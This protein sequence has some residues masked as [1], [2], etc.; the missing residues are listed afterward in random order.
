LICFNP[1]SQLSIKLM[2]SSNFSTWQAQVTTLLFG[3]DLLSYIDGTTIIPPVYIAD[4]KGNQ[5]PNPNY[6]FWLRQDSLVRSAIMASVD[7]SIAPLIAKAATAKNAW[8]SLQM[9]YAN[10]S[11]VRIFGLHESLSNIKR[12][13]K[14]VRD[15]MKEIK[16]IADDLAAS[17]SPLTN[18][19]LVIKVL[20]GLGVEYKEISVAIRARDNPISFEELFEKLLAHEVFVQHSESKNEQ[21]I[22]TAQFSQQHTSF[23][24]SKGRNHT[25]SQRRGGHSNFMPNKRNFSRQLTN[26][27][28]FN[29]TSNQQRV[30]CKLCAKFG[31]IA[32]VCRSK[33]HDA[34]EAQ[35][36]FSNHANYAANH[37]SSWIVDSGTSHHITDNPNS[38]QS[39]THFLGND[40][41]IIGEGKRIP[42]THIGQTTFSYDNT[43]PFHLHNVFCSPRIKRNLILVAKFCHHNQASIEFFPYSFCVKDL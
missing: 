2:G 30:Q 1:A 13:S 27:K 35:A 3:Y 36:N 20:S 16:S 29:N 31:H 4:D 34:L 15:Y 17:G 11:Q 9:T 25:G 37:S 14:S 19:E 18:E 26:S 41:I 32:K 38:L 5:L 39:A 12:D 23:N 8:D 42:I 40:E 21:P 7:Q 24:Q 28:A 10:K 6:K 43:K 22:I 33:S